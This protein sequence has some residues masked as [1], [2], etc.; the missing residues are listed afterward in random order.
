MA[1]NQPSWLD[2][3]EY[4]FS[5][6]YFQSPAGRLHYVDEGSGTPI[7]FVH[8]NPSWSF[9]FRN[10]I[11]SLSKSHRCIAADHLGFGLSDKPPGFSYLPSAHAENLERFL[12][13]MDLKDATLM[14]YDWGGPIGLSYALNHPERI[15]NLII[16]NTWMWSVNH[17]LR[18]II[19]SSI[20][21]GPIGRYRI[22]KS[23]YF[24]RK[25]MPSA[26]GDPRRLT[27]AA[28]AQFLNALAAPEDRK[29]CSVFP[30]QI[31]GSSK[32]LASLWDRRARL[33]GKR[34]LLAWGMKD[35]GF[36]K[37]ELGRW[38]ALFPDATVVRFPDGGHFLAEEKPAEVAS[39]IG[40]LLAA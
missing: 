26:F 40:D 9:E 37:K 19:F 34:V 35:V 28:H 39:A 21:G 2:T 23:N 10:L 3:Q 29:G 25:V 16:S 24:V 11:K 18:F 27:P 32:W 33:A 6:H 1:S 4:P 17:V 22:R 8:G 5:P 12:E 15:R 20:I 36:G 38:M 31:L 14:V 30:R 7:V 13:A